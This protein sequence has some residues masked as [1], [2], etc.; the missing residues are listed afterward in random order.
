[1]ASSGRQVHSANTEERPFTHGHPFSYPL[2]RWMNVETRTALPKENLVPADLEGHAGNRHE[3][4]KTVWWKI[5]ITDYYD[6]R[7]FNRLRRLHARCSWEDL[8]K[9]LA[10]DE[11]QTVTGTVRKSSRNGPA[12][13]VHDR[14]NGTQGQELKVENSRQLFY[15]YSDQR[16]RTYVTRNHISGIDLSTYR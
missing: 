6:L 3:G 4:R 12:Y 2:G 8:R 13:R 1:M 15:E 7:Y 5:V 16:I 11:T 9:S 10:I 14:R